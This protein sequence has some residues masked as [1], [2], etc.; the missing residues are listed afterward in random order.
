[1]IGPHV[2]VIMRVSDALAAY[3]NCVLASVHS[4]HRNCFDGESK[5]KL[6]K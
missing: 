1:M 2:S 5:S 6:K 3:W 4:V